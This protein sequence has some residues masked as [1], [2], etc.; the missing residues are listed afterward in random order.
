MLAP[1]DICGDGMILSTTMDHLQMDDC[2][3]TCLVI[4]TVN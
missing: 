4:A 3:L 1:L 2:T